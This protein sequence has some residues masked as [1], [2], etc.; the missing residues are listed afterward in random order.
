MAIN[1]GPAVDVQGLLIAGNIKRYARNLHVL[2]D[3]SW[4]DGLL[5]VVVFP[6]SSRWTLLLH[7]VRVLLRLHVGRGGVTYRRCRR[8]RVEGNGEDV[9][10]Q[11]DGDQ[12]EAL[13]LNVEVEP[14]GARFLRIS[15]SG[16]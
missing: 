16:L 2:R 5:D 12:S 3:A 10:V 11:I 8:L 4:N 9:A 6:C 7:A 13:P 15:R 1:D 14:G